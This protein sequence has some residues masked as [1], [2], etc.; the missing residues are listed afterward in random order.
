MRKA[1]IFVFLLYIIV[2]LVSLTLAMAS[3]FSQEWS[4][5]SDILLETVRNPEKTIIVIAFIYFPITFLFL[6][7][8]GTYFI[9]FNKMGQ[10][11]VSLQK[12]FIIY[13]YIL[14]FLLILG[15]LL[16]IVIPDRDYDGILMRLL[17]NFAY[18]HLSLSNEFIW[19]FYLFE[20]VIPIAFLIFISPILLKRQIVRKNV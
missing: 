6:I 18:A 17:H 20:F 10:I 5:S 19:S 11:V 14:L 4:E 7:S 13:F 12:R 9:F 3:P 1:R 15:V 2:V 8:V 16:R